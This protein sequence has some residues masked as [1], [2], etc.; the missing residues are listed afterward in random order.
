VLVL[1]F[2]MRA[3]AKSRAVPAFGLDLVLTS[4]KSGSKRFR[5][6][7]L[8]RPKLNHPEIMVVG[9]PPPP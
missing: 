4:I 3:I 2:P 5:G 1:P 8:I 6:L 7:T 9:T